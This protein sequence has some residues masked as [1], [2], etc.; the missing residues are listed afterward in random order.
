MDFN[1][2]YATMED[3]ELLVEHRLNMWR[4]IHPE[5]GATVPG[6]EERTREWIEEKLSAGKLIGFVAKTQDG[7]VAGSGCIWIR[8]QQPIPMSSRLEVPYLMSIYTE[9]GF[10][11]RGVA[12]LIVETAMAWCRTHGYDRVLLD[13]SETGKPLYEKL[14]FKPGYSMRLLL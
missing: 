1:I 9:S 2:Q 7:Q 3:T 5:L 14:G 12:R 11:R 13:A 8:E 10:R 4:D 6:T